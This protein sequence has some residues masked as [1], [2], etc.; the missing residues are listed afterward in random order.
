MSLSA[1]L[2]QDAIL[3]VRS[4]NGLSFQDN[5]LKRGKYGALDAANAGITKLVPKSTLQSIKEATS[6]ATSIDVF[7]KEADGV[8][9]ARKCEG[10]GGATTAT[11]PLTYQPFFEEFQISSIEHEGNRAKMA[12]TLAFLIS[13]R[14]KSLHSRVNAAGVAYLEANALAGAGSFGVPAANAMQFAQAT[15]GDYFNQLTTNMEENSFYGQYVNVHSFSQS[16]AVRLDQSNNDNTINNLTSQSLGFTH[17]ASTG[18]VNIPLVQSTSYIFEDG[19][20]GMIPWINSLSKAG[21]TIGTDTWGTIA[22]PFGTLGTLELKIKESCVDN[23]ATLG[24][25]AEADAVISYVIGGE[26][27]FLS[28]YDSTGADSGIYKG[29]IL[30]A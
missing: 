27:A 4:I 26:F 8:L 2:L 30:I 17:Y 19:T 18:V 12:E 20:F 14:M 5:E 11:V 3:E 7:V 15:K 24:A 10:T 23:S 21:K 28:A 29:E 9:T 6:Q 25:G 16:Q 13:E 22:D 1:T